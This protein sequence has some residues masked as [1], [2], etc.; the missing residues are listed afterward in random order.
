MKLGSEFYVRDDVVKIGRELIGKLLC[1]RI[2]GDLTSAI[3][4]ETEAYAGVTDRASHAFGG[5]RTKRT[6][7]MY[8]PGGRAY[9]YLCYGLHHLFNVVTGARDAPH[10]VLVRAA[11]PRDGLETMLE[12]RGRARADRSLMA[13]PGTLSQ[14]LGI[15]TS[16]T[17]STLTGR[18]IWIEDRGIAIDPADV[19]TGPRIGVD[20]AGSDAALPYRFRVDPG[21]FDAAQ[22]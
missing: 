14:A 1:T 21:R 15:R 8:G 4:C 7:P 5:R 6:E 12:R 9:V 19:L 20:Y 18:R 13:G 17:G 16:L 22:S 11:V 2:D 10:A 3:I